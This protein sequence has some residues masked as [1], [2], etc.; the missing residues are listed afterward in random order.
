M[1]ITVTGSTLSVTLSNATDLELGGHL[2][3]TADNTKDIGA[4]GANRPRTGY[5]GTS[6]VTPSVTNAG[7]L[8][9]SATG[10]NV[11]TLGTN[12]SERARVSSGGNVLVGTTT[13]DGAS[14]LLEGD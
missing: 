13:D 12:G 2:T 10:A 4:S 11:I 1:A 5:Y 7:T 6:V 8:A 3:W 9:L 14:K